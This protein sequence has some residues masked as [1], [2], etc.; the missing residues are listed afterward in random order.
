[1]VYLKTLGIRGFVGFYRGLDG[2]GLFFLL[3]IGFFWVS[4]LFDP[5]SPPGRGGGPSHQQALR[6]ETG[7]P[8]RPRH[9]CASSG[10]EG[11]GWGRFFG[12]KDYRVEREEEEEA[13]DW[14]V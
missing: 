10:S 7:G 13:E 3:S 2:F 9:L 12:A 6:G 5:H 14:E 1:M 11:G 8:A 4:G